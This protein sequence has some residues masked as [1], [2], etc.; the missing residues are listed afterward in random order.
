MKDKFLL[1][2]LALFI[3]SFVSAQSI[4]IVGPAADGWPDPNNNPN[5]DIML[6]DNGD[7]TH[8]IDALQLSDGEAKFRTGQDWNNDDYGG[9]SFPTGNV[10][11]NDP[12]ANIQVTAGTYDITLDLNND[13]YSFDVVNAANGTALITGYIDST[14]SGADGR[15]VEVYVD[16]T[17][18]FSS[19]WTLERQANGGGFTSSVDLSA[20]GSITDDFVY[21]SNDAAT[22][23]TE[24]SINTNVIENGTISSNG[25]DA[26]QLVDDTDAVIDRFGEDGVDGTGTAWEHENT[27][28]YRNDNSAPNAGAFDASNWTVGALDLLDSEGTCNGGNPFSDTVPFGSFSAS[29]S[30]TAEVQIIHN[31]ADPNAEFVDVYLDG[32]LIADNLEF[33]TASAFLVVPADTPINI[34]VAP[35][36]SNETGGNGVNDSIFNLNTTLTADETYIAVANGVLDPSQFDATTNSIGF[37]ID[38]FVGAQQSSTN[39]GETSVLVHH[40]S[41]DAPTV[42]V[43]ETSVPAGIIVDDIS[44]TEFQGY[45]DLATQDYTLDVE[46][47][48][49]SAVVESYEAPLQ[50]LGLTDSAITVVASGFLDPAINQNGEAFGLWVA[51]PAGGALVP[52][53]VADVQPDF[54]GGDNFFDN[55]GPN[56]NY[57]NDSDEVTTIS[58][59]NAGD[60]VSVN[61]LSFSTEEN[62]D[63]L[64]IYNG[65]DTSAPLFDSGFVNTGTG[66]LTDGT[67]TGDSTEPF[68]A[69]GE[70]FISTHPSGALTFRFVSDGSVSDA[71]WEANVTCGPPPSCTTPQNLTASNIADTSADLNWDEEDPSSATDGYEWVVMASGDAPDVANAVETGTVNNGM[72]MA[73]VNNLVAETDYDAYVRSVCDA[74]NSEVSDWSTVESFT[75]LFQGASCDLALTSATVTSYGDNSQPINIDTTGLP[76]MPS[77]PSCEGFDSTEQG[78]WYEIT[79]NNSNGFAL[80]I[81]SGDGGDLEGAIYDACGGTE[82]ICF[83][84]GGSVDLSSEILVTGLDQNTTYFLQLYTESFNDGVFELAVTDLP[85]CPSPQNLSITN[86]TSDSA[87]LNFTE[88]ASASDGYEYVL[89]TDGTVPDDNTT[90]D[91]NVSDGTTTS[92][93][94]INLEASTEYDAY[95]RSVCDATATPPEVS[96]WSS[97]VTFTT[98]CDVFVPDYSEDFTDMGFSEVPT[99]WD[100]ADSGDPSIGPS[101]FGSG[102]WRGDDFLNDTSNSNSAR[103]NLYN[104]D[105]NSWLLSPLFDLSADGYEVVFD[106]GITAFSGSA[107]SAMG[108]DDE[109]Q[110]LYSDDGGT[111]WNNLWL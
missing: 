82:L 111:T 40:G 81:V 91:G 96:E 104:A 16:G 22:L 37:G 93:S 85:S 46:L 71:G 70:T 66:S 6:T 72:F 97:A 24:F 51:L 102:D 69:D 65:P 98:A 26:F 108:S 42:D 76:D 48:D 67:W 86:I 4:G 89:F 103:I 60:V 99:C 64:L 105:T 88:E 57:E 74:A 5:P 61:F 68:T 94:L 8:S 79:T 36:D 90:P 33:R 27:Y 58:P 73:T 106:I 19:G 9:T 56:D 15:T 30:S 92:I 43:R 54:C 25:D 23:D 41:T 55:G 28:V 78:L 29:A 44:Y 1:F 49:N 2:T 31:S 83:A 52:L 101:D 110:F 75:T 10:L 39:A 21:I 50:T 109:V 84:D 18:D 53:P 100:E 17:V 12:N 14:C 38:V 32:N 13:T 80:N 34:D 45:L 63:G 47:G 59:D 77:V 62:F 3:T 107:N 11:V 87:L 35:Q 20:F 95:L 7:G